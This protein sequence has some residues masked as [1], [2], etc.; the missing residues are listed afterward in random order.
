MKQSISS[1]SFF[2]AVACLWLAANVCAAA[3]AVVSDAEM[4][5]VYD[6]A[7]TPY[8]YGVVLQPSSKDE[9]IDCPNV[10]RYGDKW[11]MLYVAIKD[12]VGYETYLAESDDLL[13]WRPLGKVL[14]FA[15][16]GWDKWQ[17]DGSLALVDPTWNGSAEMHTYDG[18]YWLSYFG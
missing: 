7:K 8:K 10:F 11:Y 3:P 13:A 4:Q 18:K 5:R 15:T 2:P 17:A 9:S 1:L 6:Q 12:K 16:S 14:P